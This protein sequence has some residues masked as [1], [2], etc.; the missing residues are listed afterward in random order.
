MPV[1][2]RIP[3]LW[4]L[5]RHLPVRGFAG[6]QLDGGSIFF[7]TELFGTAASKTPIRLLIRRQPDLDAKLLKVVDDALVNGRII[8]EANRLTDDH[9]IDLASFSR[10]DEL[11]Q[12]R[13]ALQTFLQIFVHS[14][15]ISSI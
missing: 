10:F 5:H 4:I 9:T 13:L 11:K 12:I 2:V 6:H 14:L 15:P 8:M 1:L 7:I 3:S